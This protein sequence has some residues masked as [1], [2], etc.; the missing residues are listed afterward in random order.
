MS[1]LLEALKKAEK[2]KEEAQ[3]RAR[4][5]DAAAGAP[6]AFDPESTVL[7]EGRQV[8]TRD[9]LPDISAPLEIVSDDLKPAAA[10][11]APRE[12]TLAE[13]PPAAAPPPPPREPK[14]ERRQT[15]RAAA[16]QASAQNAERATAQRVFEAKFKE[17]NPRLPFFITVGVLGIFAIGTIVYFWIQLRPPAPLVNTNPARPSD[18]RPVEVA[19]APKPPAAPAAEAPSPAAIPG[20]PGG[21][22]APAPTSA[23]AAS[24]AA[25]AAPAAAAAST[26]VPA[27]P[28]A[29][30]APA[31]KPAARPA[32]GAAPR[33]RPQPAPHGEARAVSVN[34][35]G[36]QIHPL[37]ASGYAAYQAG[38]LAKARGEYQQALRDEPSNRDAL[39]GLAAVE[40]RSQRFD[41]ADAYYQRILQ[42]D[43][44]DPH[45][46]AGVIALRAQQLDP[47]QVESRMKSLIAADRGATVLHFTLGNQYAQQG[48]WSEAQQAYFK[49]FATD[50]ENPDFAFNLAVS[51]DQL[52]QRSLAL[53]YYRRALALAQ[54]RTAG[55]ALEAANTR[56]QQLSR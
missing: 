30:P 56:V 38:D 15:A 29:A 52:H 19:A 31:A 48:R 47:V 53:E 16:T 51:L 44:R 18:E 49:A 20:L 27:P 45:A 32:A 42:A 8:T 40:M 50:P 21:S 26:A 33:E 22:A 39:L 7:E 25:S 36:P 28:M 54:K 43:P 4:A 35:G 9:Q 12:L 34:R 10:K 46:Q 11:T 23:P 14:P 1:L 2:A 55:F 3:R 41:L 13:E 6:S 5:G 17:P 37:V 24:A